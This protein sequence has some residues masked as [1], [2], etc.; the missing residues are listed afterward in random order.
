MGIDEPRSLPFST[1]EGIEVGVDAAD[2]NLEVAILVEAQ[3]GSRRAITIAA[4]DVR[5]HCLFHTSSTYMK[6][7]DVN[8]H[9][10]DSLDTY[11]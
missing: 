4:S 9:F 6:W 11:L 3:A 8:N 5:V 2:I 7:R 10:N 1:P